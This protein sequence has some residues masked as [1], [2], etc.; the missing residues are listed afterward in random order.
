MEF[1]DY[2]ATLGVQESATPQEIKSAYRKLAR[3][4]HPDVSKEQGAEAHFK[5]VG[6]AYEVLKDPEKRAEYD[7]LRKLG[8]YQKDGSFQPPPNWE[9]AAHFST[10]GFTEADARHFSDFFESIFGRQGTAH[11]T[12]SHTGGQRSFRMKGDDVYHRMAI[13]LEES[14]TGCE[15]QI[16]FD[17]PEVDQ[18]GL[19][20]HQ[21]KTL[22]VKLPAGVFQGQHIRLKKQGS[23]GIGGAEPGDLYLEI[24][25]APH[26]I[27]SVDGK[28]IHVTLPVTPWEA[29][30]GATV[31]TPTLAGNVNLK[32]PAQAQSGQK[33]RLKG[34]GL[35]GTPP[36]D[37]IV[38]LQI[39]MP[40]QQTERSKALFEQLAK[41][42]PFNPRS[43]LGV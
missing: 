20:T 34:K 19:V 42:L 11:R 28:N 18:H 24:E 13:F 22:K 14:F 16:A 27:Y 39:I 9:S 35:P 3:K 29:A 41:E 12:Y 4:Y 30:L 8:A 31:T 33:L 10:G 36:G 7:Q 21:R 40:S 23:P 25:I 37:Q 15:R 6:E 32:I 43:Q 26:P 5:E 1:K 38:V 2:Y 17:V